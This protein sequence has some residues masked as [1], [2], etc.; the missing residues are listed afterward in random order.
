V[1]WRPSRS[2]QV[3]DRRGT[4]GGGGLGGLRMGG[5]GGGGIP[6]P[7]GGGLGGIVLIVIV[8]VVMN[9]LGGSGGLGGSQGGGTTS[10][11]GPDDQMGQFVNSVTVDVQTFWDEQFRASGSDYPETVTV[12]FTDG[13]QT[14]CGVA[15]SA[16]GPFYC[17]ADQ[18][19]YLDPGFFDELS[20]R[21]GA[22][23][24]FAQAYVI[25]HEFG[26]HVQDVLGTMD[27]VKGSGNSNEQSIRLELQADCLAG[28]WA[29]W[30]M[31]HP[32]QAN[33]ESI[34]DQDVREGLTAAAAVG[35]DRIQE[36]AT[37][38]I[39]RES[40]THGSSE[41]RMKWFNVGFKQGSLDACDT[42]AVASP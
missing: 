17:P 20:R 7:V 22:P 37:G 11:L 9:L 38:T 14:G 19:V 24:D 8:I 2:I 18:K 34:T 6:I 16:T 33:V 39:D 31:A 36:Q 35:D 15:S 41:Q 10:S 26:H 21:F 29:N 32:D 27:Q 13:T 4:G 28:M 3:E 25:A 1:R 42:F 12:L 40:W 23:G 30:V 5:L